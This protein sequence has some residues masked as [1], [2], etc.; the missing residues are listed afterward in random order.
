MLLKQLIGLF[1]LMCALCGG[2]Q[3]QEQDTISD[4]E[5]ALGYYLPLAEH[6]EPYA[7]LTIAEIYFEGRGI[8]QDL[9][10]SY[11]WLY[12]AF[13]QGVSEAG[14][15]MDHVYGKMGAEQ[16]REGLAM[17][18]QFLQRYSQQ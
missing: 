2:V 16:R 1:A 18:K 11:A 9:V 3:A 4:A 7:Q 12:V 13:G 6:G 15:I 17:G 14:P 5:M 10:K 8:E